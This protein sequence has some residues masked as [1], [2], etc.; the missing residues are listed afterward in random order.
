MFDGHRQGNIEAGVG[1]IVLGQEANARLSDQP[2]SVT[3]KV[4]LEK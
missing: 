1:D 3:L 2:G 4:G